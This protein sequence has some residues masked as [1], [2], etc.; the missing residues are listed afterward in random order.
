ME[1]WGRARSG[2]RRRPVLPDRGPLQ[3]EAAAGEAGNEI[4]FADSSLVSCATNSC[5][6]CGRELVRASRSH[7]AGAPRVYGRDGPSS[8]TD[9]VAILTLVGQRYMS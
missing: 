4:H 6:V 1:Q 8:A 5:V 9:G 2:R 7:V 3:R